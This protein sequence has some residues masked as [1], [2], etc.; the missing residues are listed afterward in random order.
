MVVPDIT[1]PFFPA[2]VQAVEGALREA[3]FSLLLCDTGNDVAI[4]ADLV[5][6]LFDR[7]VDGLLISVCDRI[8]SRQAVRLAA[9]RLPL[10]QIDRRALGGMPYVGV[11]QADAIGQ[12]I[13]HLRTQG[14]RRYAYLTPHPAIST[15]KE[16]LEAFLQLVR[17]LDPHVDENVYLGDFSLEWGHEAASRIITSRS[18]PDAL[19]CANDLNAVGAIQALREH[20]IDV[21]GD[22]AVTGFDDTVLAIASQPQLTTVRQPLKDLG[23]EAVTALRAT[24]TDPVLPPHSAVLRA[25]LVVRESSCRQATG[26]A[27]AH[28]GRRTSDTAKKQPVPSSP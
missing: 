8:A 23:R 12:V 3:G 22:V 21:P 25:E 27:R 7:Q 2:V 10:I 19:V 20:G 28:G 18:L 14:A 26:P 6:N 16:R 9:S 24:I 1:N 5:R 11:D 4:E 17:P 15:A 13:E